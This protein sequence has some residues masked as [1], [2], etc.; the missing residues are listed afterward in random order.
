MAKV[1]KNNKNSKAKQN[2]KL[3]FRTMFSNEA[4]MEG[5]KAYPWYTIIIITLI[6]ILLPIVPI[7]VS[8]ANQYGA[9]FLNNNTN[10]VETELPS[11]MKTLKDEKGMEFTV[12][13]KELVYTLNGVEQ[14][15]VLDIIDDPVSNRD[16]I[17]T[18]GKILLGQ[19]ISNIQNVKA[20]ELE[21]YYTSAPTKKNKDGIPTFNDIVKTI[22]SKEY[23][24]TK[25]G[26]DI[27]IKNEETD[28]EDSNYYQPSYLILGPKSIALTIKKPHSSVNLVTSLTVGNWEHTKEGYKLL[29]DSLKVTDEE[30]NVISFNLFDNDY[31]DGFMVNIKQ[32]FNDSYKSQKQF[33][34]WFSV[35]VYLGIYLVMVLF[36]GLLI[37]LM[38]RGKNNMM[39][40]LKFSYCLKLAGMLSFTPGLL[41]L[42][43]GFIFSQFAMMLFVVLLGIRVMWITMKQ[44]RP[45]Q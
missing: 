38:T 18:Q 20:V 34:M 31:I 30:G 44:L 39:N 29:E 5:A 35:V 23:R 45:Q 33:N 28:P 41:G 16:Q 25:A 3:F 43:L 21:I 2:I 13:N 36:M 6:S 42:I 10:S 32:I 15:E 4:A 14:N 24:I 40:Y 17:G 12:R 22:S 7:F 11:L 1:V 26:E 27:A 8:S 19:Y 9:S 37:F